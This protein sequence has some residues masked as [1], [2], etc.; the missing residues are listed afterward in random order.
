MQDAAEWS[1]GLAASVIE[2][3]PPASGRT[4]YRDGFLEGY[5]RHRLGVVLSRDKVQLIIVVLRK[6]A[7]ACSAGT[8][9]WADATSTHED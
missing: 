1:V 3:R 2:S 9:A 8:D 6:S 4:S 7:Y 5:P